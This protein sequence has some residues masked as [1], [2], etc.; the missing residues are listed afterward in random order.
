MNQLTHRVPSS[1][2][3]PHRALSTSCL[4]ALRACTGPARVGGIPPLD[5]RTEAGTLRAPLGFLTVL[6]CV[7]FLRSRKENGDGW[8]GPHVALWFHTVLARKLTWG[9]G[10]SSFIIAVRPDFPRTVN[11]NLR[12]GW[13]TPPVCLWGPLC[14]SFCLNLWAKGPLYVMS[15][16]GAEPPSEAHGLPLLEP[17]T[18]PSS[19]PA[20]TRLLSPWTGESPSRA[21]PPNTAY[22]KYSHLPLC[23]KMATPSLR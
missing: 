6:Q 18:T 8:K 22:A 11:G 3:I 17:E 20:A 7:C 12:S 14:S 15:V 5:V 16:L 9:W 2:L 4:G 1:C 21:W 19:D 10:C 23:L 13:L